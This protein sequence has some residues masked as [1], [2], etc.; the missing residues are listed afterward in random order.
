MSEQKVKS[1]DAHTPGPWTI[2]PH[3]TFYILSPT[4]AVGAVFNRAHLTL[5][6]EGRERLVA[7]CEANARLIAAAPELLDALTDI[8]RIARAATLHS[9]GD[10]N[11]KRIAKAVAA[12]RKATEPV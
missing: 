8:L 5:E 10:H 3:N 9:G 2:S 7:E 1:P 6:A 12:I 4:G 11:K